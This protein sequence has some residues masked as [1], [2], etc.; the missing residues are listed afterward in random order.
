VRDGVWLATVVDQ[1]LT[2][3]FVV[4]GRGRPGVDVVLGAPCDPG[5]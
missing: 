5:G 2:V 1:I 4:V 3:A